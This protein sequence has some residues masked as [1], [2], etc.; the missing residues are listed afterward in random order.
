MSTPESKGTAAITSVYFT[1]VKIA[2][3]PQRVGTVALYQRLSCN[4]FTI[5]ETMID[6]KQYMYGTQF[7]QAYTNNWFNSLPQATKDACNQL[8]LDSGPMCP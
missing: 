3:T 1:Q 5:G 8:I 2:A 4:G 6:A 7:S